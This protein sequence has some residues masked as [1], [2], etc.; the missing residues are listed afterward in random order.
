MDLK[1]FYDAANA[2]SEKMQGIL[3]QMDTAFN[4]GTEEGKQKALDLRP[5]LDL[6]KDEADKANHLYISMRDAASTNDKAAKLFVPAG[7]K[8]PDA[9]AEHTMSREAFEDLTPQAQMK[10]IKGG[11]K[12]AEPTEE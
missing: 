11:G 8:K 9:E 1:P 3:N 4:E 12:I 7:A 5:D 10:F 6:A 2:A